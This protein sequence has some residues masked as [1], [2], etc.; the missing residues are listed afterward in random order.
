MN[1]SLTTNKVAIIGLGNIGKAIA[2]NLVKG[3]HQ[4]I[5]ASRS[6]SDAEAL[7]LE[8]G[9]LAQALPVDAAI[10]AAD[11][12]I[13]AIYFDAIKGFIATYQQALKGKVLVDVSNPIAPDGNGGFR[14]I[15]AAEESAGEILAALLPADTSLVKAFGTLLAGSLENDAFAE[16]SRKVLFLAGDNQSAN[17][18]VEAL[19]IAA[20]FVPVLVGGLASSLRI[21]VFGEL[22]E[23]GALGKTVTLAEV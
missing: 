23:A 19:I 22:H 21:E 10:A 15:I 18:A 12:V 3:G 7:A 5:L 8:L 14:K 20:G 11:I 16:P 4:V 2:K 1:T 9:T 17:E 13:P 6:Q